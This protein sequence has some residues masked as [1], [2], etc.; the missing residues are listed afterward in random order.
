MDLFFQLI[1]NEINLFY[2]DVVTHTYL[3]Y[4]MINLN[5]SRFGWLATG[6]LHSQ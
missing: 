3:M 1:I 2:M 4:S 5:I 6:K